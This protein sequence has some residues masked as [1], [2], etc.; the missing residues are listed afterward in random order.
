MGEA[1]IEILIQGICET[2]CE[3]IISFFEKPE[4]RKRKMNKIPVINGA[5]TFKIGKYVVVIGAFLLLTAIIFIALMILRIINDLFLGIFFASF[6]GII[7]LLLTLSSLE[8]L[9]IDDRKIAHRNLFGAI[10]EIPWD[11]VT[12][13][14]KQNNG[15]YVIHGCGKKRIMYLTNFNGYEQIKKMIRRNVRIA[16]KRKR[17]AYLSE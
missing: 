3:C 11:E 16:Q 4:K 17:G 12:S 2:I 1:I 10:T 9:I 14:E 8:R 13:I 15:D 6:P 5:A 7:G